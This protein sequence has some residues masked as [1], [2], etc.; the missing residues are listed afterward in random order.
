M[1]A[2]VLTPSLEILGLDPE[3]VHSIASAVEGCMSMCDT[4]VRCVGMTTIPTREPGN[5]TG[6]IGVHGEVSGFIT[7]NLAERLASVAVGGLLQDRF[8][9]LSHQVI[10]GVGEITNIIAGGIK[11]HLSTTAWAFEHVTVPSVIVG[12]NY[13][14]A[15]AKG[16]RYLAMTFEHPHEELF[17]LSDRL[18]HVAISLIRVR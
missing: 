7:V 3:Q 17:L 18:L 16:L 1:S 15:Y 11:K 14:I 4:P 12:Q 9:T 10:D 2:A 13:Q 6:L 8:D 5:V